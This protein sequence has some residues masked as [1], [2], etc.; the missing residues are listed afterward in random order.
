MKRPEFFIVGAP[1]CGTTAMNDYLSRHPDIFMAKKELHYFGTD[2]KSREKITEREYLD[3]FRNVQDKKIAGEA[4]VWY[5][6]SKTAAGGI[7]AFCPEAKILIMLRNP[8]DVIYSLHSQH[9]IDGNEDV[10]DFEKAIN[11]D[12]ERKNGHR[13]PRSFDYT[14]LPAYRDSVLFYDQVKR[15]LEIFDKKNVSIILFEEFESDT[16][17]TVQ[18]TFRFLGVNDN[19]DLTYDIVNSNK[20]IRLFFLHRF[21][22]YPSRKLRKTLRVVLPS[23]KI[24]HAIMSSLAASN[25]KIKKREAMN[26]ELYRNL[27]EY[28]ANDISSLAILINRDLSKWLER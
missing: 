10:Y 2:L 12:E 27:Q 3:H 7:K 18:D 15:Y 24:R 28:F 26:P 14:A 17:K 4:S 16:K 25:I 9:L 21:L 1:K 6:F 19:I 20:Q 13:L 22:K 23:K 8:V 5:L 11:L